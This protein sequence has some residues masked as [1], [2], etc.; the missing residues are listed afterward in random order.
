VDSLQISDKQETSSLTSSYNR[1]ATTKLSLVEIQ[2]YVIKGN[3][4]PTLVYLLSI[5]GEF[6]MGILNK[7]SKLTSGRGR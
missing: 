4:Y 3:F 2:L 7:A 1:V 6:N 5:A